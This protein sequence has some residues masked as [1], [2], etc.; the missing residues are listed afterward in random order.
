VIKIQYLWLE[1]P[2]SIR[3]HAGVIVC[4]RGV[5]VLI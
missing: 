4:G 5:D 1:Y 2:G 3:G